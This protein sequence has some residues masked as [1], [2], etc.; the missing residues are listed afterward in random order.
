MVLNKKIKIAI[1]VPWIK[2]KGGVERAILKVLEDRKYETAV[3]TLFYDKKNTFSDFEKYN[4]KVLGNAKPKG[5]LG[6]GASLFKALMLTK[7]PNLEDYDIFMISTAGIA[8]FITFRNGHEKTVAMCHTPLRVAHTMYDYY[9]KDSLKNRV[10]LPFLIAIYKVLEKSAWKKINYALVFSNEVRTRL[11]S[12]G[13]IDDGRIFNLGPHVNYSKIKKGGKAEKIIFYPSRFTRYKRQELAIKAFKRS[14]MP[15]KGF[16]LILGGFAEDRKY[17]LGL[18]ELEN[19]N[20]IVKENLSE[21][22]LADFYK[23]CYATLFLAI[24]EDTGLTPL[25]SLAYGKPVISV[26]EG[27]PKEFVKNKE[28]GLLVNADE[29]SVADALNSILNKKLYIKLVK[30]AENSTVYDEKRFIKNLDNAVNQILRK[31]Y[32]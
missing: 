1:F 7:I 27:G 31:P 25:E 24:N 2:S 29:Q 6:R 20:I 18:K 32:K 12:Y 22:E 28:N 26:N 8:E 30:G 19:K 21:Q 4:V 16:K 10:I 14:E 3:F 9:R 5:F 11:V 13:L 23:K 15:K 17:F